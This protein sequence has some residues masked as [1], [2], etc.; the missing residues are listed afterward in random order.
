MCN[1]PCDHL[2]ETDETMGKV[3]A[4]SK[5]KAIIHSWGQSAYQR[6]WNNPELSG[7]KHS[8]CEANKWSVVSLW[9]LFLCGYYYV[10]LEVEHIPL[11]TF[12]AKVCCEG[13]N[14]RIIF[15]LACIIWLYGNYRAQTNIAT[16]V[17]ALGEGGWGVG[18]NIKRYDFMFFAM[19]RSPHS[20]PLPNQIMV[21]LMT[22]S[23]NL[24]YLLGCCYLL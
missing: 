6:W 10:V 20:L 21:F 13:K 3:K 15:T 18:G 12:V 1:C 22:N 24:C 19:I 4:R 16:V 14:N 11:L 2:Y 17:K 7:A 9:M 23:M 5:V 8:I